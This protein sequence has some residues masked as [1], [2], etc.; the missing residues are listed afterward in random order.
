VKTEESRFVTLLVS[1]GFEILDFRFPWRG[2][3]VFSSTG[4]S[5]CGFEFCGPIEKSKSKEHRL[6]PVLLK[7]VLRLGAKDG[8]TRRVDFLSARR[9]SKEHGLSFMDIS[10]FVVR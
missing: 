1:G 2:W 9:K 7:R 10:G 6:K 4:F 8:G 5:L 3:V